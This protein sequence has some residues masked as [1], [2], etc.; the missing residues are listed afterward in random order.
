MLPI[1]FF[2]RLSGFIAE[3]CFQI[4]FFKRWNAKETI[5]FFQDI[6]REILALM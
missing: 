5:D 4:G 3:D 6:L 1:E 2:T